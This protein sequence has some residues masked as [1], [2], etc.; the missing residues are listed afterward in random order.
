MTT[1]FGLSYLIRTSSG[2]KS[3]K[4]NYTKYALYS[5]SLDNYTL[6]SSSLEKYAF[7]STSLEKYALYSS[8]LETFDV[9]MA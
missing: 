1:R 2:Q 6:Y 3:L 4:R 8:S 9:M 7:Y 5:S